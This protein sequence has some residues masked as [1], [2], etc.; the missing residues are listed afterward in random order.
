MNFLVSLFSKKPNTIQV[1]SC[2]KVSNM[3]PSN[4][5]STLWLNQFLQHHQLLPPQ[6]CC[7]IF[8]V[9][10]R[11]PTIN[12][13]ELNLFISGEN[14]HYKAF[15]R[16]QNHALDIADVAI[17]SDYLTA[18]NYVRL[19]LWV[20][21]L[22]PP[23]ADKATIEKII[24]QYNFSTNTLD[25]PIKFAMI[26]SHDKRAGKRKKMVSF[27]EKNWGSV[28]CAGK[29]LNN[30]QD[31]KIKFRDDKIAYLQQVAYNI[32][33]E[34]SNYPGYVTEKVFEAIQAGCIPIYW[35]SNNVP[36]PTILNQSAI[37]FYQP[38]NNNATLLEQI[39]N[40]N[41]TNNI[42]SMPRFTPTAAE[43]IWDMYVA[44]K[45]T[46]TLAIEQK[47]YTNV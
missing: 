46:I 3:W 14:V 36:E 35:G 37:A 2:L 20:S 26:A 7:H 34:N 30:T 5:Y 23:D 47:N 13:Q 11:V 9:F 25:R 24:H 10:G 42:A 15:K 32:C 41:A 45:Q 33:P 28:A 6:R 21:Y 29:L 27:I 19:P 18:P 39:A 8:S 12:Q 40:I 44:L 43:H 17:G 4:N 1:N 38:D 16:Y 22:F 31:L